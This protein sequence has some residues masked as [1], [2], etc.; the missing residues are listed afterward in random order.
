MRVPIPVSAALLAMTSLAVSAMGQAA[1]AAIDSGPV[2]FDWSSLGSLK[3]L[4][5]HFTGGMLAIR[6]MVGTSDTT[7]SLYSRDGTL[8][9]RFRIDIP[10]AQ[11]TIGG[12]IA[13][14]WDGSGY[15]A[16]AIAVNGSE[17]VSTL[18]FID[19]G[20]KLQKVVRV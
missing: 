18:C 16:V 15:V 13:P 17:R 14:F 20:G 19:R 9:S 1:E 11:E 6:H 5:P 10:E 2:V 7:Y 4:M 8:A 3:T 12:S